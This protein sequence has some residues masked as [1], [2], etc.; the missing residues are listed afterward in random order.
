MDDSS[1]APLPIHIGMRNVKT[2]LAVFSCLMLY[3]F[4]ERDSYFLAAISAIICMQDTVEKSVFSGF[5]RFL[6]TA[7]GA[8]LGTG[9]LYL[10]QV[11]PLDMS[12]ISISAVFAALGTIMLITLCNA[13][14]KPETITIGCVV[15]LTIVL[16]QTTQSPLLYGANRLLDTFFGILIAILINRFIRN[17]G[18]RLPESPHEDAPEEP[19]ESAE[20][21]TEE[22]AKDSQ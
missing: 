6:G 18:K 12:V 14:K 3:H 20:E 11:V 8:A 22:K 21:K 16:D 5:N 4:L 7:V 10:R 13:I 17:P 9:L 2:A 15:L 1:R 19:P